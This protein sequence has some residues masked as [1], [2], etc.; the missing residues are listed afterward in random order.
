LVTYSQQEKGWPKQ[1]IQSVTFYFY[2]LVMGQSKKP[3]TKGKKWV[4]PQLIN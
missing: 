2:F 3:I 1:E 4:H